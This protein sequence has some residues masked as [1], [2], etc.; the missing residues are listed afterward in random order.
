MGTPLG[1]KYIPYTFMD[2]LGSSRQG[3]KL[4]D[5]AYANQSCAPPH[6][7][8]RGCSLLIRK[9]S[10]GMILREMLYSLP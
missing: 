5:W 10:M 6:R 7:G 3:Q 8:S 4:Q 9:G 2:P 1:P